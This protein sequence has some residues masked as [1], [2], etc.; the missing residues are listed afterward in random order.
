MS[1]EEILEILRTRLSIN[2]KTSSNYTGG[3]DGG[4][5]YKDCQTIQ[6]L[7]DGDVIS[8]DSL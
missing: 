7:L 3:M 1:E 6:L 2:I 4:P 8:E 5:M